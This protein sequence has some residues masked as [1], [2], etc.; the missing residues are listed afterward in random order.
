MNDQA[1]NTNANSPD[2]ESARQRVESQPFTRLLQAKLTAVGADSC[3][4][5]VAIRPD[6]LQQ[7]G[8]V[9]GGVISYAA[10]NAL[11][12]AGA[13]AMAAPVVTSEFKINYLR[14]VQGDAIIARARCVHAGRSQAVSQCNIVVVC[15]DEE[16]LCAV[17]Q[18]TISLLAKPKPAEPEPNR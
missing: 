16:K 14:P 12:I 15:G 1:T 6:L 10:D 17:A 11:T 3:E 4:L 13:Q 5:R 2:L 7:H 18:G 9:H 8:F